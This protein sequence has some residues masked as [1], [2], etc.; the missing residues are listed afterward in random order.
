MKKEEIRK[1]RKGQEDENEEQDDDK[2]R[3]NGRVTQ[4]IICRRQVESITLT[5][6][7]HWGG[8]GERSP[9]GSFGSEGVRGG[10]VR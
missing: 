4:H 5:N 7:K 9:R 2:G 6:P 10:S 1:G 8:A 3:K